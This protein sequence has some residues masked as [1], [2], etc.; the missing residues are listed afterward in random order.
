ML[1]MIGTSIEITIMFIALSLC[2]RFVFLEKNLEGK[3]QQYFNIG[4]VILLILCD[5]ILGEGFAQFCLFLL[6]GSNILLA[7]KTHRIAG[8]FMVIP[9]AGIVNGI[10][11]PVFLVVSIASGLVMDDIRYIL[12][13]YGV[14]LAFLLLFYVKGKNWR[15]RFET[16][17]G[18]R[19]LQKWETLLLC[20]VGCLMMAF[21]SML[22]YSMILIQQQSEIQ[23]E[24]TEEE[25][26]NSDVEEAEKA[27]QE[28]QN[29]SVADLEKLD[30]DTLISD[31][32]GQFVSNLVLMGIV[33]FVLAITIIILIMQGNKRAYYY[34]KAQHLSLQMVQALANTIDAKDSYTNGHSTRV[35]E[36]S[37]M[38]AKRMG[39]KGTDVQRIQYAALLHDIGKIGIPVEIINKPGRLTD[40]E[41]EV[42]KTHPVIGSRIL[43]EITELPDI[44][45][46]ARFHH[47][48][49]DGMG[50]PDHKKE[51]EIPE[52]ARIIGVA[53]AYDAM[54]SKRSYRDVLPQEVV[55]KEIE[56]GKGSQFDPEIAEI[57][58][59]LI[60]DD[61]NYEMHE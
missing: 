42:I 6:V 3:K 25:S 55:R 30:R 43:S 47:E 41:Y 12:L 54:T 19:K 35:A 10:V 44:S 57:M 38:I 56:K 18:D 24:K 59:A 34:E 11:V 20:I 37:V 2:R 36:Y 15:H 21:S 29:L 13:V 31:V 4:A 7:R 33:S 26:I 14:I 16:E 45:I 50:Y 1:G 5:L 46:G 52:I 61:K 49:Y 48:R 28:N 27:D 17:M 51:M 22:E 53:D 8:F 23:V 32:A 40:E 60:Y 39:Y 9:I 58:L